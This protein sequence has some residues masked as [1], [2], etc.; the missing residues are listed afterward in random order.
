MNN[1]ELL[2][3][4]TAKLTKFKIVSFDIFDTLIH[5][6]VHRPT[7]LFDTLSAKLRHNDFGLMYPEIASGFAHKRIA[8]ET[9]ARAR[10]TATLGTPEV[11]L[12][13]IYDV[14][15]EHL[16]L[17]QE[18]QHYLIEQELELE[19]QFCHPNPIM[20]MLFPLAG[21]NGRRIV[22]CSDMY[23]PPDFIEKFMV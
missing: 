13:E 16:D 2:R 23:L 18:Q 8:A 12:Q 7:D 14:L 4:Y 3:H 1:D 6:A 22:L 11:G 19:E 15:A 21:Q 20:Q 10:L 5:R 9:E 17:S